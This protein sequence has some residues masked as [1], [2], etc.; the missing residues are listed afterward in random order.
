MLHKKILFPYEAINIGGSHISSLILAEDLNKKGYLI[1]FACKSKGLLFNRIKQF[2]PNLKVY[3]TGTHKVGV[4]KFLNLRN[5]IIYTCKLIY[6][7]IKINPDICHINDAKTLV[8]WAI[9]CKICGIKII[10]HNRSKYKNSRKY[11]FSILLSDLIISISKYS[12][13]NLPSKLKLKHNTIIKNPFFEKKILLKESKD[14]YR[15]K[16]SKSLS[17]E[18]EAFWVLCVGKWV[19]QKGFHIAIDTL[20]NLSDLDFYLIFAGR[21]E[22]YKYYEKCL[23]R[24]K[25]LK[26]EKRIKIIGYVEHIDEIIYASDL[27]MATAIG[28]AFGRTLIEAMYLKT[29]VLALNSGGH[30]EIITDNSIGILSNQ[31]DLN[32]NLLKLKSEKLRTKI[33]NSAY[34]YVQE[35]TSRE[36]HCTQI[37]EAY[38]SI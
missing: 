21:Q 5:E 2:N 13:D 37:E 38:R 19:K 34:N 28:D 32:K 14:Q 22:D 12:H 18:K 24:I 10:Y 23:K 9:P 16:I 27:L 25:S 8:L 26:M 29:P 17:I 1:S 20:S 6:L 4:N 36:V 3:S 30:K 15:N 35:T 7:L 11:Y 33:V 31:D